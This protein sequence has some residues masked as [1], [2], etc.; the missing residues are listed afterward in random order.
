M[1]FVGIKLRKI[2]FSFFTHGK[3]VRVNRDYFLSLHLFIS[4]ESY[5]ALFIHNVM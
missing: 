1:T 4:S 2:L 5:A 3:N